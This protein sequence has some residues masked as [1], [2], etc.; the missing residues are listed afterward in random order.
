MKQVDLIKMSFNKKHNF[1]QLG[2]KFISISNKVNNIDNNIISFQQYN[3]IPYI[4]FILSHT[5]YNLP[6]IKNKI[7]Y[8]NHIFKY[9]EE[10]VIRGKIILKKELENKL[11]IRNIKQGVKKL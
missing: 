8:D 7:E 1:L 5:V 10:M 6:Y 3:K 4:F 2:N 11:P 9:I